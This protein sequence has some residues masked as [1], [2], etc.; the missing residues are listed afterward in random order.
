MA[1]TIR[2]ALAN[3]VT[4]KLHKDKN[5]KDDVYIAARQSAWELA[6]AALEEDPS[7]DNQ[8]SGSEA[9]FGFVAW[10]STQS[11]V[12]AIGKHHDCAIWANLIKLFCAEN[13]LDEPREKWEENLI[14]PEYP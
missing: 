12:P 8:L 5:G 14:H 11:Y 13:G 6:L 9:V 1:K 7:V 3:L 2:Q 10:L 4:L